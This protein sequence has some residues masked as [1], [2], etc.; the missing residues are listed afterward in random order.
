MRTSIRILDS[1]Q[2]IP[3]RTAVRPETA[4][5]FDVLVETKGT[6]KVCVPILDVPLCRKRRYPPYSVVH[7]KS[8][9]ECFGYGSIEHAGE[10]VDIGLNLSLTSSER[11][12][13]SVNAG[14]AFQSHG[15]A[16]IVQSAD[17]KLSC[18]QCPKSL[19]EWMA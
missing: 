19:L 8:G 18:L 13:V 16:V 14:L 9:S 4:Q 12:S 6:K 17:P 2:C 1:C 11:T 5:T 15:L 7:R 10:L 3:T